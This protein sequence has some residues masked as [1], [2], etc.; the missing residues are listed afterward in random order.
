[1]PESKP[2]YQ[3]SMTSQLLAVS[4]I[5]YIAGCFWLIHMEVAKNGNGSPA[6]ELPKG[7]ENANP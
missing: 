3:T 4:T 5:A 7:P 6:A 1:M 2:S